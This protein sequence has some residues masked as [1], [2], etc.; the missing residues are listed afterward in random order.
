MRRT[1]KYFFVGMTLA[2]SYAI[3]FLSVSFLINAGSAQLSTIYVAKVNGAPNFVN[4]PG[5]ESFWNTVQ[6]HPIPLEQT[7]EYPGS[8][9]GFTSSVTVK[10]AWTDSTGTPE[11]MILMT[12]PNDGSGAN[13]NGNQPVPIVNSTIQNYAG[14]NSPMFPNATAAEFCGINSNASNPSCQ[15]ISY[16]GN[17]ALPLAIG[18]SY[19]YPEQASVILGIAPGAG[20]DTWYQVSY[21]PKMVVGTSGA[22]STGT[23]GA[24]EMWTWASNPTDNSSQDTGYPGIKFPNGTSMDPSDFGMAK[25]ASYAIDGYTNG[26][27]YYQIG[28]MPGSSPFPFQNTAALE[29]SN[30]SQI[31]PVVSAWNPFEVQAKGNYISS[32]NS[33]TVEFVRNLTT[34]SALGENSLQEQLNPNAAY[35]YHIAFSVSQGQMSQTYLLYYNSVSFWWAFNFVSASGFNPSQYTATSSFAPFSGLIVAF[36]LMAYIARKT[37]FATRKFEFKDINCFNLSFV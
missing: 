27:S 26:S 19:I 29:N 7:V 30:L 11:L 25:H 34:T 31:G 9:A 13:W 1:T 24:A 15:G 22:L 5:S 16:P 8:P 6:A 32:S 17:T 12:F 21:K 18:P 4:G 14:S 20:T 36:F 35:N 2:I 23:G 37:E 3:I 28:G 10:M 33:W